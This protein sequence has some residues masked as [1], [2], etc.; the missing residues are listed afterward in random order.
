MKRNLREVEDLAMSVSPTRLKPGLVIA[1]I[2]RTV[3]KFFFSFQGQEDGAGKLAV[4]GR[5][6]QPAPD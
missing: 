3:E 2:T 5:V 4:N 1:F 6:F